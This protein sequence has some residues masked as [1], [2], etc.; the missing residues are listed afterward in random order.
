ML[1]VLVVISLITNSALA[2]RNMA[3]PDIRMWKKIGLVY[4]NRTG[5]D[6][7]FALFDD[8]FES[9][10]YRFTHPRS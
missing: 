1:P 8:Y 6:T 10:H 4:G 5:N 7:V 2:V 9:S 3:T